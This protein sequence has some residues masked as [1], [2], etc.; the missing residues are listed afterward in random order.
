[1]QQQTKGNAFPYYVIMKMYL[2]L[3]IDLFQPLESS[4]P[5]KSSPIFNEAS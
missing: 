2:L 1:M 5:N 3:S 4:Q